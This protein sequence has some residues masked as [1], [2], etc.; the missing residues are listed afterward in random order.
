M[1][2]IPDQ[3]EWFRHGVLGPNHGPWDMKLENLL[4]MYPFLFL[5]PFT[6]LVGFVLAVRKRRFP[7]FFHGLWIALMLIAM[8]F[9]QLEHLGWLID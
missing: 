7:L 1:C 2:V 5:A 8:A 3:A 6:L 4:V 9:F